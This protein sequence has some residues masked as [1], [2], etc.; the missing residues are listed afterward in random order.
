RSI[1]GKGRPNELVYTDKTDKLVASKIQRTCLVRFYGA[2]DVENK[3]IPTPYNR[4]GTGNAFYITTK[5]VEVDG[6]G[7]LKPIH[8]DLPR[9][10]IQGFDPSDPPSRK[11]LRGMDLYCGGGNFGRG[12][13]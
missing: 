6:I 1:D 13:E 11:L 10:L 8:D 5:L 2:S 12:L 3:S 9:T 4:D 7:M